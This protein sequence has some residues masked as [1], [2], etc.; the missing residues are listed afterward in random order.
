MNDQSH[1]PYCDTL[2]EFLSSLDAPIILGRL[3][4]MPFCSHKSIRV[5]LVLTSMLLFAACEA[6]VVQTTI[7][8]P[9]PSTTLL[10]SGSC[11]PTNCEDISLEV[12][13]FD[14]TQSSVRVSK[15]RIR[16]TIRNVGTYTHSLE[17]RTS[18]GQFRSP[19]IGPNQTGTV[20]AILDPGENEVLDPIPGH[21]IRG[22]RATIVYT[23]R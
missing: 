6:G 15:P 23:G 10:D 5:L 18:H 14:V 4:H 13:D 7:E 1:F 3:L 20:L 22:E 21:A 9:V 8:N 2:N 16:V 19:N 17:I 12:G 11:T